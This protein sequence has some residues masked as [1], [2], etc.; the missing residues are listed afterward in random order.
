[1]TSQLL[2]YLSSQYPIT[3]VIGNRSGH[4]EV[5]QTEADREGGG[6]TQGER[7]HEV[8]QK[9][10]QYCHVDLKGEGDVGSATWSYT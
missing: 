10:H 5:D 9:Y 6:N 8:R 3:G 2:S 1:M 4:N 7:E